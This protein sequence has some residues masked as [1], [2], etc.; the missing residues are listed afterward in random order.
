MQTKGGEG[1]V[2]KIKKTLGTRIRVYNLWHAAEEIFRHIETEVKL[3]S[4]ADG[5][6]QD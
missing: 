5:V 2:S 3:S 6:S 1:R 4:F